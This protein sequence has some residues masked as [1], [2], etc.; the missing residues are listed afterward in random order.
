M[1]SNTTRNKPKTTQQKRN[2]TTKSKMT[3]K[4][5]KA[6][7]EQVARVWS[8]VLFGLSGLVL[9]LTF[10]DGAPSWEKVSEFLFGVFGFGTYLIA[11]IMFYI[12]ILI[13][14]GREFKIRLIQLV[15][16]VIMFCGTTL[17]FSKFE[18]LQGVDF[19][20]QAK[21]LWS[22]GVLHQGGGILSIPMGW[23]LLA[24]IGDL[25]AKIV[26]VILFLVIIMLVTN[27]TIVDAFVFIKR[28]SITVTD[29]A[30]NIAK[31]SVG[32]Y[33][34]DINTPKP[35]K[36][37]K[38]KNKEIYDYIEET[39]PAPIVSD[40]VVIMPPL[41]INFDVDK[42][43]NIINDEP[44]PLGYDLELPFSK[45]NDALLPKLG[46]PTGELIKKHTLI[47][48]IIAHDKL[49]KACLDVVSPEVKIEEPN[50]DNIIQEISEVD[51]LVQKAID[52]PK[53]ALI[54]DKNNQV[55]PL[56]DIKHSTFKLPPLSLLT[57]PVVIEDIGADIE[58]KK[59]AKI[60]IETL[61]SFG[62]KTKILD[63]CRGTSVTRYE[64]Q[65]MA[66]VKIS[67]ITSLAD[68][69]AL[70]FAA[71]G[72]RIEAPIPGKAAVGIEVPN[73]KR[74]MVRIRSVFESAVFEN[75]NL[76]LPICLGID[77]SGIVQ[78]ADLSKMPHM[79]I[80]GTTGSGKSVCT[81]C[82]ILSL[83][84]R[85]T[86]EQLKIILIDPKVVEF[87]I[88]NGIPHLIMPV[89]TE[90]RKAAGALGSAVAEMEKRYQ[91]F[92]ENNVRDI[93]GFNKLAAKRD[94]LERMSYIVIVIDEMA[95]LMMT[96]GKEVEDYV[97]RLAQKSRAAGMH[98]IVATQR[99]SVDVITG[100]IKANIPSRIALS[101][102]S[103]IDSRTIIDSGGAEKL[104]GNGDMLFLPVGA[105]K[106][107]RI[108]GAYVSDN[109]RERVIAYCKQHGE[110]QYD[111][112]MIEN[113]ERIATQSQKKGKMDKDSGVEQTEFQ[114]EMLIP[115]LQEVINAGQAS[116]SMLQ[117]KLR[118]G[119]GRAGRIIDQM[120]QRGYIGA[121]DGAKPRKVL[122]TRQEF[123][124][125]TIN[126]ID[127]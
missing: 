7:T 108:Q 79:L 81:N 63:I 113:T 106:P 17:V 41:G 24:T 4:A 66:G 33:E 95:D 107:L 51:A 65:P 1:A 105:S 13:A 92:A 37:K 76:S 80:A 47:T 12:A 115:A 53:K 31:E 123:I 118:L 27:I 89:I 93:T 88:Y 29:T 57:A 14:M 23:V 64:I 77:I 114:D 10:L 39:E 91:L 48:D 2:T 49:S 34:L 86:P 122:I 120:E 67:R 70:N 72:V 101:L 73:V 116:T 30:K 90:P 99:P 119:Y 25:P 56:D 82:I 28:K 110:I 38:K 6:Q 78:I 18:I 94:D 97:C 124:E 75:S 125:L 3:Q 40:D 9:A 84:Y 42:I 71:V 127:D 44:E 96:S 102:S 32:K 111:E 69:I 60:L 21:E 100:L 50:E 103:Q 68:D 62:V 58:M 43:S 19:A 126:D 59:N 26:T 85:F 5:Q 104:L 117:R 36:E 11:P 8:I 54:I 52:T 98:L 74:E 87:S 112:E 46:E 20:A 45:D 55:E 15:I 121:Y 22:M 109:E 16:A 83:L 35:K 61:E